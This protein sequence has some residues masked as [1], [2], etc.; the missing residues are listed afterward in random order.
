MNMVLKVS[1]FKYCRHI[2]KT[3]SKIGS[4][5][6]ITLAGFININ[7]GK[8]Y[9]YIYLCSTQFRNL[10]GD[11]VHQYNRYNNSQSKERITDNSTRKC[12]A[13]VIGRSEALYYYLSQH[14]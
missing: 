3:L 2:F 14:F 9:I 6:N 10:S 13:Q 4:R 11:R 5:Y 7:T 12:P 8:T 1:S